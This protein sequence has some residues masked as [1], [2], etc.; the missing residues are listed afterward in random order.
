MGVVGNVDGGVWVE[1]KKG[2]VK[3]IAIYKLLS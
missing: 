1:F 3:E 2:M